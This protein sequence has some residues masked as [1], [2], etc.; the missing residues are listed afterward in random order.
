MK[1]L[2]SRFIRKEALLKTKKTVFGLGSQLNIAFE[3][4]NFA[5]FAKKEMIRSWRSENWQI[6]HTLPSDKQDLLHL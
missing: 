5:R 2:T 3:N 1:A 6:L 4:L